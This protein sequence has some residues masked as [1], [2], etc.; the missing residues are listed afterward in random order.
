MPNKKPGLLVV[1]D[2]LLIRDL[3]FDFFSSNGYEVHLAEDG[4][5]ALEMLN[6][7]EFQAALVDL[8]MPEVSGLE[9]TAA[10][11]DKKPRVPVIIMTAFPSLDSAIDSIRMGVFEYIIK[12]FKIAELSTTVQKAIEEYNVRA[13]NQYARSK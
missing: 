13:R 2:E 5:V 4:K 11:S 3:L 12:P 9:V 1:D 7:L 6:K 8:K 10:L